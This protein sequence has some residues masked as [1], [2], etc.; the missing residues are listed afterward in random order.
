MSIPWINVSPADGAVMTMLI[1][2]RQY[3]AAVE[4]LVG[5]GDTVE[6]S[7]TTPSILATPHVSEKA[8]LQLTAEFQARTCQLCDELNAKADPA[9]SYLRSEPATA[10]QPNPS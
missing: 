3:M 6:I 4:E 8:A 5:T 9:G 2:L 7:M 10:P 1:A